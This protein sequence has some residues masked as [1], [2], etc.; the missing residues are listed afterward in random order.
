[1]AIEFKCPQCGQPLEA[2]YQQMGQKASCI[3]CKA[4]VT[5][6]D[7]E[8]LPHLQCPGCGAEVDFPPS[9]AG[10]IEKCPKCGNLIHVPSMKGGSQ[11]GCAALTSLVGCLLMAVLVWLATGLLR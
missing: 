10:M 8:F 11:S 6:P 7:P 9:S 1:M 5:V 2:D 3:K 4:V